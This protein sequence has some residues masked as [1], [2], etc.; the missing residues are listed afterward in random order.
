MSSSYRRKRIAVVVGTLL[1]TIGTAAHAQSSVTLFGI[2]D[3]AILYTS[4]TLDL[5]N[6]HNAGHQFSLI[7]GGLAP[8][9]FGLKGV[10]DLGGGMKAIFELESG[11]D[12]STGAL[13]DSNGNLF[14][15]QAWIGLTGGF[16]TVKAGVQYSP[17]ALSLIATDPR[18]VSYFGS[19]VPLYI[20]NVFVTGIFNS[21]SISY[22]SPMIAGLQ[23]SAMLALGGAAGDFQA[24]R[25]YSASLNYTLGP[26][27]VSAA[28]YSGNSGGTA[29]TTP[30]P[31]T[32]AFSG[33][34]IGASYRIGDLTMKA[35]FINFK[36]AGSFDNR[37]Y[38]GGL[39]YRVT[40]ATNIDAGVWYTSDGNDTSNHSIMAASGLT[41]NLSKATTLYTQLGYVYN[42]GRMN[43][44]LS[45]NGALFGVAGS[46]VG[47]AAGIRHIF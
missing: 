10:E 27:M 22:T 11:I 16:G 8:S 13:T 2:A 17:F 45:T 47:V 24:G 18:N 31:S 26:F 14:G 29:A 42:H 12:L 15:R 34:T 41:Y 7:T 35:S 30:V 23:G 28:L 38:G 3:S 36:T 33:R 1:G 21:N 6:G 25:Q 9:V 40:P 39:S 46:T 44:G 5:A 32:V 20:S 19:G 43:T 4:K 37:I